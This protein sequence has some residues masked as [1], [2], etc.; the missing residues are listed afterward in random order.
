MGNNIEYQIPSG[1]KYRD[2]ECVE[3]LPFITIDAHQSKTWRYDFAKYASSHN[4]REKG[5]YR[6][7][8]R[9]NGVMSN[10]IVLRRDAS[11]TGK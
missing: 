11:E 2:A 6:I 4:M 1:K 3:N 10:E 5:I 7:S 9:V 8:W